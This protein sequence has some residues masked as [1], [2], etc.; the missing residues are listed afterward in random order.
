[1]SQSHPI[2]P[3]RKNQ[4]DAG[5]KTHMFLVIKEINYSGPI[6]SFLLFVARTRRI[7]NY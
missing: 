6:C 4:E 2:T 7:Y 1:M 5:N 3:E